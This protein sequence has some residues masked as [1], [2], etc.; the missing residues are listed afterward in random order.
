MRVAALALA[1]LALSVCPA[2]AEAPRLID[3][4]RLDNRP[5]AARPSGAPVSAAKPDLQGLAAIKAHFRLDRLEVEGS[6]LPPADLNQI[7]ARWHGR[8]IEGPDIATLAQ[9]LANL[10]RKRDYALFSILVPKQSFAR[11]RLRL[12]AVE[13]RVSDVVIGGD[14]KGDLS[15]VTAY[16]Q[17]IAAENPLRQSTLE[18]YLLLMSDIPGLT[19]GSRFAAS[20]R[21]G[22]VVLQ[23]QLK[24]KKF[25]AGLSYNNLGPGITGKSQFAASGQLNA[26][27]RQGER[28]EFT[29]GFPDDFHLYHLYQLAHAEPIGTEGMTAELTAAYLETRPDGATTTGTGLTLGAALDYPFLRS[30]KT[31]I[32]GTAGFDML[33]NENAVLGQVST[34]ERTRNL[35]G[36]LSYAR[37]GARDSLFSI[38]GIASVGVND[39]G[40]RSTGT[41][42]GDAG[43]LKFNSRAA[44][45]KPLASRLTFRAR[46]AG[47][48]ASSRLP[49]SEQLTFGGQDFGGG[50]PTADFEGDGG[51]EGLGELAFALMDP[52]T[53]A[54]DKL[55]SGAETYVF[56]DGARLYNRN[57]L[58][59]ASDIRAAS[60]GAGLRA[61]VYDKAVGQLQVARPIEGEHDG[62]QN[63]DGW[64]FSFQFRSQF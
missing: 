3:N 59:L 11:G 60:A 55:L 25:D 2:R 8:V 51:I 43:F 12:V 47:Q 15:L 17:K 7:A 28:S 54:A 30:Q 64:L 27:L 38:N 4:N 33:N 48:L 29:Y 1:F 31:N 24:Q 5:P 37:Q 63:A 21:P 14:T 62:F 19:V 61:S 42:Y 58:V 52:A 16:G 44:Y 41:A 34:T 40:A 50:F 57:D 36:G 39:F 22:E 35:R 23:L 32:S 53:A 20:G 9:Q 10:Y 45:A 6:T 56:V 18:R 49:S 13:G 26:L 46:A